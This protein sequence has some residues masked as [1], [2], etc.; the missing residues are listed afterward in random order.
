MACTCAEHHISNV[1]GIKP[2]SVAFISYIVE[3]VPYDELAGKI[4]N[5]PFLAVSINFGMWFKAT[6]ADGEELILEVLIVYKDGEAA[7]CIKRLFK[8]GE[9]IEDS[10]GFY[11]LVMRTYDQ[12]RVIQAIKELPLY[13]HA[14]GCE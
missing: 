12:P 3:E 13:S 5:V 7:A 1:E 10:I 2:E 11:Q 8:D 14:L 6:T 4:I 9:L